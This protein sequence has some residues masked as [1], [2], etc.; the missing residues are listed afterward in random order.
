M[1]RNRERIAYLR[2]LTSR[3][4]DADVQV[5]VQVGRGREVELANGVYFRD[6]RR[7]PGHA[8]VGGVR[9]G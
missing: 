3:A 8:G 7:L 6:Y 1:K 9:I 4:A 2:T 5:E